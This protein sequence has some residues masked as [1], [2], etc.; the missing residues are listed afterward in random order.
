[1]LAFAHYDDGN[2]PFQDAVNTGYEIKH[3]I[4]TSRPSAQAPVRMA[5]VQV[6]P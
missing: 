5:A 2:K 6:E 3:Q 1:V 4:R